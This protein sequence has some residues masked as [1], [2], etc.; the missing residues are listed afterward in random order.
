M[1]DLL[2]IGTS[3]INI[4][5][6]SLA[7]TGNNIANVDTE[8][9]SRQTHETQQ[10]IGPSEG[11]IN[12]G[13]GVLSDSVRRAYDAYAT[14]AYRN[15]TSLLQQQDTLYTYAR[16]LEDILADQNMS[17]SSSIDR[18]FAAAQDLSVSPSSTSA[19]ENL[20]NEAV[21]VIERFKSLSMQFDRLDDDSFVESKV[22]A[23]ELNS[24]S[25]QLARVNEL[26]LGKSDA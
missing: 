21:A 15:S 23:D 1:A 26:M 20:L 25:T 5:R 22:R 14:S 17:M 18:F 10:A 12:L 6:R 8:G 4:Y 7:T 2:S 3:G 9:Y 24:L 11:T 13:T 19:R 16:K